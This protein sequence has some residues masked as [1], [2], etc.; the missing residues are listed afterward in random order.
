MDVFRQLSIHEK[1]VEKLYEIF[2]EIDRDGSG[3]ISHYE[4]FRFFRHKRFPDRSKFSK[5]VFKAFDLD[6]SGEIDFQEFVLCLWNFCS[7]TKDA[8]YRLSFELYDTDRSGYLDEKE[9]RKILRELYGKNN[10]EKNQ[11]TIHILRELNK[12]DGEINYVQFTEFARRYPALLFPAFRLQSCL[13]QNILGTKFWEQAA[14]NRIE[15]ERQVTRDL[16]LEQG[17][18]GVSDF[19]YSDLISHLNRCAKS[20]AG[21]LLDE[22]VALTIDEN[23]KHKSFSNNQETKRSPP[24]TKSTNNNNNKKK[25]SLKIDTSSPQNT[26]KKVAYGLSPTRNGT[27][28]QSYILPKNK[29]ADRPHRSNGSPVNSKKKKD[30][31]RKKRHKPDIQLLTCEHA[32]IC[33]GCGQMN[34]ENTHTCY[35]CLITYQSQLAEEKKDGLDLLVY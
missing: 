34:P 13:Q 19:R 30:K 21:S 7:C 15:L 31:R 25:K 16:L 3:E 27:A 35:V 14:L 10:Y 6:G 32:W 18:F 29:L 17:T 11:G 8:L 20:N 9:M 12:M 28:K 23:E 4:F 33:K 26:K 1:S 24:S 22:N 2:C 5:K